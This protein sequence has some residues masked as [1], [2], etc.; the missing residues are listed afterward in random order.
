VTACARCGTA[1]EPG[2]LRCAIC[3][4]AVPVAPPEASDAPVRAQVLRCTGCGAAVGF[5][6]AAGA[7]RCGFCG[8]TMAIEAPHDPIEV[9]QHQLPLA[10]DRAA[11]EAALRG[12]LARR[13]PLAPR[14]LASAAVVDGLA[15]LGWAAWR[16]SAI[17]RVTWTA[18]SDAGAERAAWAPHAGEAELAFRDVIVPA[19]RGLSEAE[20]R[21]LIPYYDLARAAPIEPAGGGGLALESF[22]LPRSAARGYVQDRI[23]AAARV[24]IE[25]RIPGRR[26]RNV[27]VACVIEGQTTE[28]LAL[29]AW[30][31]SYRHR[32]RGY[33]A[34]VHGQRPEIVV[35]RAP[36][37]RGK[38]AA[39]VG[40]LAALAAIAVAIAMHG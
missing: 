3:A 12:W 24:R 33:R 27:H 25:A 31:M 2:D 30:V 14:A 16:V 6:P 34:I 40:V 28:R 21:R 29:P 10:V 18:D 38:L 15:P 9:A 13:G 23:A 1:I 5:V 36:V 35:G 20:A 4:L 8:A 37:D 32:G 11:A 22:E 19:T 7:P 17:A 26:F 39:L